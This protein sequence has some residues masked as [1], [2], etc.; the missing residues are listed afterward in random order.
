MIQRADLAILTFLTGFAGKS[1]I[2]DHVVNAI[3]RFDLFKGVFIMCLFW[4]AWGM[5]K[6]GETPRDRDE[7][8]ENLTSILI[9]GLLTGAL[10]RILQLTLHV[11]QRP[12]LSNLHLPFPAFDA[13]IGSLN[14]WNSFPSDHSMLFFALSTG[15][16]TID[17]RLGI[18]AGIWSF[19]MIDLPRVYLGIHYPSDV[20]AG[21][22]IGIACMTIYLHLPLHKMN[23]AI[24]AWRNQYPGVF[25]AILFFMTDETAHLLDEFRQLAHS[26]AAVLLHTS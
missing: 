26:M 25:L 19:V 4:A 16:W 1:R 15:L 7:R 20:L 11:H 8:H 10:S 6:P 12:M 2:F 18:I 13:G 21:A 22:V 9:G 23:H 14:T 5:A 3:S 24:S 17:R